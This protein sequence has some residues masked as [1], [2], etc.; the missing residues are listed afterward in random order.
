[1]S[2]RIFTA[3]QITNLSVNKNV[4]RCSPKSITYNHAFKMD[5]YFLLLFHCS[6]VIFIWNCDNEAMGQ[7]YNGTFFL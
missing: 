5:G 6:I 1:M 3:K 2:K 4:L 7:W